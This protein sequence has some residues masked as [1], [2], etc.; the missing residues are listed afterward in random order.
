MY[1]FFGITLDIQ[2]QRIQVCG[3]LEELVE[4]PA[5]V[6]EFAQGALFGFHAEGDLFDQLNGGVESG[7]DGS[8]AE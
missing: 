7:Y 1:V 6:E 8:G 3:R 2:N 5:V 4:E